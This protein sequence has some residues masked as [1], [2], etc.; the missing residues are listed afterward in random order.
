MAWMLWKWKTYFRVAVRVLV[1]L[2][3]TGRRRSAQRSS[4][5]SSRAIS[6]S[7]VSAVGAT[8]GKLLTIR[9]RTL[10]CRT[11]KVELHVL[12]VLAIVL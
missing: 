6:R 4:I 2:L 10:I 11:W 3:S 8:A 5:D 1:H 12:R 9:H 7:Q